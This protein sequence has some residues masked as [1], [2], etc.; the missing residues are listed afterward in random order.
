MEINWTNYLFF[1]DFASHAE[2]LSTIPLGVLSKNDALTLGVIL[3]EIDTGVGKELW[4]VDAVGTQ[5]CL[6]G[7]EVSYNGDNHHRFAT[8]STYNNVLILSFPETSE[9]P[10][11]KLYLCWM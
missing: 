1:N 4:N 8:L 2:E 11:G 9:G 6:T 7:A 10:V 3:Q 5:W